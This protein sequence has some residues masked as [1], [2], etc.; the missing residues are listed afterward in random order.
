MSATRS[1][2]GRR[3]GVAPKR[4]YGRP[5]QRLAIMADKIEAPLNSDQKQVRLISNPLRLSIGSFLPLQFF[6]VHGRHVPMERKIEQYRFLLGR[7]CR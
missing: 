3:N 7:S 2:T 1:I 4:S 5:L 6:H